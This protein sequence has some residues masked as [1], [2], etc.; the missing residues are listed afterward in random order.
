MPL[1][2]TAT[3]RRF[4]GDWIDAWNRHDPDAV[5]SHYAEDFEFSSPLIVDM[6][7][8]PSSTLKGK[9]A[10]RAYWTTGLQRIPDLHFQL[11]DVLT[12]IDQVTLYYQG[13]RGRVT[14]CFHFDASDRVIRAAASV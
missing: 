6:V 7:G 3:A 11:L 14:E 4:A 10:V 8:E 2:D 9:A 13:H 12:G 1:I 5:L